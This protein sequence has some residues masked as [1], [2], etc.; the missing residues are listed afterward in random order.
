MEYK[1]FNLGEVFAV[2]SHQRLFDVPNVTWSESTVAPYGPCSHLVGLIGWIGMEVWR[3]QLT[4]ANLWLFELWLPFSGSTVF[5]WLRIFWRRLRKKS[6]ITNLVIP[7]LKEAFY[8]ILSAN[9]STEFPVETHLSRIPVSRPSKSSLHRAR[10]SLP[11]PTPHRQ[12][13][14]FARDSPP[15]TYIAS[16]PPRTYP[17]SL[18]HI[19]LLPS[20][21]E[22]RAPLHIAYH[23]RRDRHEHATGGCP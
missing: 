12:P 3:H 23:G 1:Y 4:K 5:P 7:L 2:F 6:S 22:T 20:P 11:H 21:N 13:G 9:L 8:R 15:S 10:A 14:D 16:R 19:R 18:H 17:S